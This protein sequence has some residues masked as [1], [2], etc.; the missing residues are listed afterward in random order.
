[1]SIL[2]SNINYITNFGN[3]QTNDYGNTTGDKL[4]NKS[5]SEYPK[6]L[7]TN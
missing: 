4:Q 7:D 1:M 3:N 5:V 6:P 2:K